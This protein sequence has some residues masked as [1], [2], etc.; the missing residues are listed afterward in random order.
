MAEL[1][2]GRREKEGERRKKDRN[3]D[4]SFIL[5]PSSI[6][7]TPGFRGERLA[8]RSLQVF[9][10]PEEEKN[11]VYPDAYPVGFDRRAEFDAAD[12]DARA[13]NGTIRELMRAGHGTIGVH[14]PMRSE[15]RRV[16][17]E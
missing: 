6:G 7:A 9:F 1:T 17:E 13:V 5:P 12:L 16:G 14:N 15:E 3:P 11:F 2:G 4:S 8:G 10:A